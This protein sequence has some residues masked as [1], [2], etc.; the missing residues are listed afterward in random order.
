VIADCPACYRQ[1]RVYA[2]QLSAARGLV[3]CGYCSE[4]FNAIDRL[5]D[6]PLSRTEI[7]EP[8]II[9]S[10]DDV[11]DEPQFE[12]PASN[13]VTDERKIVEQ[14]VSEDFSENNKLPSSYKESIEDINQEELS[15]ELLNY[16]ENAQSKW[17][18]II[19]SVGILTLLLFIIVQ[20]A[21][22]NRDWLLNS[23]PEYRPIVRQ[24]CNQYGCELIRERDLRS[25]V[26]LNRDV[27]DHPRYNGTLLVNA[28]IE[29]QSDSVQP[30]PGIRLILYN[31]D[32]SVTGYRVF[33][34]PEYLDVSVDLEQGMPAKIPLHLVLEITGD[35]DIAVSFEFHFI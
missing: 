27:R 22:F 20:L 30:Y 26:L 2:W 24:I 3:Q 17:G 35:T 9:A 25:I 32:G 13:T 11:D 21:W 12:I 14:I 6:R 16:V 29:N 18:S 33:K 8:K 7:P 4:Q 1:Y 5:Y 34:P 31:T 28:T 15:E 19:W 23:Y 10:E